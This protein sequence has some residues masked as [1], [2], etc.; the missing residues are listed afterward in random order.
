[1]HKHGAHGATD[2]TGFGIIGHAKYV[3][4]ACAVFAV[5]SYSVFY[6]VFVLGW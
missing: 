4:R 2:V 6:K 5:C 3:F 1:M